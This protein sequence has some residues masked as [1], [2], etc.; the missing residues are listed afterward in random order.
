MYKKRDNYAHTMDLT[1][2]K[3]TKSEWENIESPVSD[4]EK[5]VLQ[6]IVSG[7]TDVNI[8][9]NESKS[10]FSFLKV[11]QTKETEW[12]LYK[13]YFEPFIVKQMQKYGKDIK[14]DM[15]KQMKNSELKK[16]KSADMFRIQNME[17]N[18]DKNKR[19]IYE[20]VLLELFQQLVKNLAKR[21]TK[22]AYYL[23]TIMQLKKASI[24]NVN[25]HLMVVMNNLLEVAKEATTIAEVIH[26]AHDFIEKNPYL[27][28]YSDMTLYSHQKDLFTICKR[29]IGRPKLVLYT[30][31]TGT[32]K[33]LSPLG[34]VTSHRVIFVCVA[35]HI[36]LALAKS[37][38]SMDVKTAFAFGCE[39]ASDVRL[40]YFS[41][42]D[43]TKNWRSGGIWKVDNSVGNKVELMICDVQSYLTAMH[44]M[45]AFNPAENIVTY[46]DEPTITLDYAEHDLHSTIQRNWCENKIP[47]MVMS[48][49]T[50]PANDEIQDMLVDFKCKFD[51]AE[52]YN[53]TSYDCKK[54]IP[55]LDSVGNCV[56]L[57]YMHPA[58][59]SLQDA[60]RYC[61]QNKTLLRYFDLREVVAF[62]DYVNENKLVGDECTVDEY[63]KDITQI[64][65]N[66]LKE[67]YLDVL[68]HIREDKWPEIYEYFKQMRK[69]RFPMRRAKAIKKPQS[70]DTGHGN[71]NTIFRTQSMQDVAPKMKQ[72]SGILATTEDAHTLTDG[73]T[74][75][76]ADDI[77]KIGKFYI[78]QSNIG[79]LTLEEIH[80]KIMHND[81]I[82]KKIDNLEALIEAKESKA[83]T[84][85]PEVKERK[86]SSKSSSDDKLSRESQKWVDEIEKLNMSIK[87]VTLDGI[88]VPNMPVHQEK[89]TPDGQY[90]SDAFISKICSDTSKEIM[91]LSVSNDQ[92]ILLMLGIGVFSQDLDIRYMELM[93]SLAEEQ[94]L[95]MII[96]STDYIYGTNYQFCHGY[97]GKDLTTMT[98]QKTL[99]AMGRIG[100]NNI[101]QD[102]TIRFRDNSM[103]EALFRESD[104]NLEADNMSRLFSSD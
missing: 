70:M 69:S 65:M 27:L 4:A 94:S 95:F 60:V 28:K 55:I 83:K 10:M 62:V 16:M 9:R 13:T 57:H 33:T 14:I 77:N 29:N 68:Q 66:K 6:M 2:S 104:D 30:A 90:R 56:L 80:N 32:G 41:A 67:Y 23:Y 97:I 8:H 45:M 47:T 24:A 15:P 42:V 85:N 81:A 58:Y 75:F 71:D 86:K 35:R 99:Q 5:T 26:N 88:Y 40:H 18:I 53:I 101:Q 59:D 25:Q 51:G 11:E 98:R 93:K 89:W 78:Q 87:P 3:L 17:T 73:P 84:S 64:T 72:S 79:H 63:F 37:A 100:R 34:L 76:L 54:S 36:G 96:A 31:P 61:N 12:F 1:Q 49:A 38:I 21:R 19:L 74:I 91:K 22:Y 82:I 20:Y 39:T 52:I 103:Y 7:Y 43:Y 102:Y 46:W 92:K 48:C 50:L 44:Y